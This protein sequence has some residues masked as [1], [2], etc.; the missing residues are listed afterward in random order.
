MLQ[1]Y[2]PQHS[3]P[4]TLCLPVVGAL[5][6]RHLGHAPQNVDATVMQAAQANLVTAAAQRVLQ[7]CKEAGQQPLEEASALSLCLCVCVR[8]RVC[9]CARWCVCVCVSQL[10]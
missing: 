1:Q 6:V 5:P 7:A 8:A 9:A 4:P 3:P 2:I 10:M